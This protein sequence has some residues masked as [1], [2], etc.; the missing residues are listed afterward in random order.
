LLDRRPTRLSGG[1]KQRVALARA[2]V[3]EPELFIFDEPLSALDAQVRNIARAELRDLQKRTGITT[4]YV[5]HDQVEALGLADRLAVMS[6]GQ[7]RQIGT[8][9]ELYTRP[10]DTFVASFIGSPPMNLIPRGD[11]II[12]V[13]PEHLLRRRENIKQEAAFSLKLRIE[14]LEYL[15]AEYLAYGKEEGGDPTVQIVARLSPDHG[16]IASTGD[17]IEFFADARYVKLF[18]KTSGKL[19]ESASARPEAASTSTA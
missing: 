18:D 4:L 15:G 2:L 19:L 13:R 5:T 9:E 1:E 7:V 10:A 11:R 8:P 12:G 6:K 16:R 17:V 3:R 14:Q